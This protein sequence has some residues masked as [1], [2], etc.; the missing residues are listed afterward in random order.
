MSTHILHQQWF[1]DILRSIC[2]NMVW[3]RDTFFVQSLGPKFF[4]FS[5]FTVQNTCHLQPCC[6]LWSKTWSVLINYTNDLLVWESTVNELGEIPSHDHGCANPQ[7]GF[8]SDWVLG[9]GGDSQHL[10]ILQ[11]FQIWRS[12]SKTRR[13]SCYLFFAWFHAEKSQGLS[14]PGDFFRRCVSSFTSEKKALAWIHFE[15]AGERRLPILKIKP[16]D[17]SWNVLTSCEDPY[18]PN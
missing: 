10:S 6:E 15:C 4:Y 5:G 13:F 16:E 9:V 8:D 11:P 2:M 12:A 7:F 14:M 18:S 3:Y 17:I 1:Q